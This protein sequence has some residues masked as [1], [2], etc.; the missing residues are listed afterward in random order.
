MSLAPPGNSSSQR[1]QEKP[2]GTLPVQ[3]W[4]RGSR[5]LVRG[6]T[7]R[8]LLPA[9][10]EMRCRRLGWERGKGSTSSAQWLLKGHLWLPCCQCP[11]GQ[12]TG[13]V[14]A[15]SAGGVCKRA[16]VVLGAWRAGG[17]AGRWEDLGPP[18]L[19]LQRR[20]SSGTSGWKVEAETTCSGGGTWGC[21]PCYR[22]R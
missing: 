18:P 22:H 1:K 4:G 5:N 12:P 6:Q 21:G 16:L 10:S 7:Q 14:A 11:S 2:S 15:G 9:A 13:H 3:E 19:A 17:A 8:S 20:L